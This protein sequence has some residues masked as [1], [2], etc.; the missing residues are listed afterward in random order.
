MHTT[1]SLLSNLIGLLRIAATSI[2]EVTQGRNHEQASALNNLAAAL[3][4]TGF[5]SAPS[6]PAAEAALALLASHQAPLEPV[7]AALPSGFREAYQQTATA[8]AVSHPRLAASA[9]QSQSASEFQ[10]QSEFQAKMLDLQHATDQGASFLP[11]PAPRILAPSLEPPV[12][13]SEQGEESSLGLALALGF[14]GVAAVV[15][16]A[17]KGLPR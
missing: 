5:V 7:F 2:L 16:L 4:K 6:A 13:E 8:L 17:S 12:R 11:Q 14:L 9:Q 15:F 3:E 1:A 10:A